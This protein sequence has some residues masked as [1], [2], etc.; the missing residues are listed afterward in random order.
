MTAEVPASITDEL[1]ATID[2][3]TD[4]EEDDESTA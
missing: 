3:A 2:N 4:P 1:T